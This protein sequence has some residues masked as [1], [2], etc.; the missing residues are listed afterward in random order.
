MKFS[1]KFN[2]GDEV[3]A[4]RYD[5]PTKFIVNSVYCKACRT[6]NYVPWY[7]MATSELHSPQFGEDKLFRTKKELLES[8]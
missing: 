1:T 8:L 3:W 6:C 4:M 7:E 2:P 5:K